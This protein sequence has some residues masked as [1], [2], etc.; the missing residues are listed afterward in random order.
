MRLP[1]SFW[2]LYAAAWLP[3]LA[4]YVIVF[5]V[6]SRL[7]VGRA[8]V[9]AL[10]NVVPASLLGCGVVLL[11]PHFEQR[12]WSRLRIAATH[13]GGAIAFSLLWFLLLMVGLTLQK[14]FQHD[15]WTFVFFGGP[16]RTWQLL[17]GLLLYFVISAL[18]YT[19]RATESL[20]DKE[21]RIARAELHAARADAL[22]GAAELQA[23]RARL[24]PHFL[25]NTLHAVSALVRQDPVA[26]GAALERFAGMMRYVLATPTFPNDEVPLDSEW[27]FV[28]DYLDLE[29]LR[30][31]T[32]LRVESDL[33]PEVLD[34]RVPVF[35][36]Q[37]LVENAVRYA[38][39]PRTHGGTISIESRF[40]GDDFWLS[41]ADDGPG[42]DAEAVARSS[43][44][45]LRVIQQR[46]E[47]R[48]GGNASLNVD[49][50]PGKGF[51]VVVN[52]AGSGVRGLAS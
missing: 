14:G 46:L 50:R 40:V 51:R 10:I 35:T 52:I 48:Y 22:R 3:F 7:A 15:D 34:F 13:V 32:R 43:G 11:S 2:L 4:A 24:N 9:G 33:D 12:T 20:R 30:L 5:M 47:V 16:A 41:V 45:G 8:F 17:Q 49:C 42:A 21:A 23:L 44:I 26:A 18:A 36:L 29:R 28:C 6:D 27:A 25:F 1:R 39:A 38:V 31:G 37:P 19:S